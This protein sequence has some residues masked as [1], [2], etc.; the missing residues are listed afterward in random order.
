MLKKEQKVG[1]ISSFIQRLEKIGGRKKGVLFFRGHSDYKYQ[2]V[3]SIYRNAGWIENEETMLKELMLRCP[4]DFSGGLST[5]QCLVKMQH[6]SLPTR[7]LDITSN[8]LVAL[9]FACVSRPDEDGEVVVLYFDIEQVKYFDSDT[10]SVISNICKR[11]ADFMIPHDGA[12]EAFNKTAEI[13]LLLHDIRQDKPHFEP[14]VQST[15]LSKVVCVKPLLDN[16]RIIR[17]DGAFLLFGIDKEKAKPAQ[18]DDSTVIEHIKIT[19]TKKKELA[20]QLESLGISKATMFPE[21]EQVA[22]HIKDNYKS[23][24][25]RQGE[26]SSAQLAVLNQMR[27]QAAQTLN[28]MAVHLN[29]SPLT[30]RHMVSRLLEKGLVERIGSGRNVHWQAKQSIKEIL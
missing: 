28:E 12:I 21:I 11:P 25:L 22:T 3:P 13:K 24:E 14:I 27:N 7:L 2:L 26:L 20:I 9:Y 17:Q 16:P 29:L 1:A 30:V 10:V 23:P 15:H 6:Y 19:N 5:F 4:N 18:L 8:P